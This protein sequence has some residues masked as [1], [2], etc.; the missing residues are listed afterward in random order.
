MCRA[1]V[2]VANRNFDRNHLKIV[3]CR[4]KPQK[5]S[6]PRCTVGAR[7]QNF[8]LHYQICLFIEPTRIY[9]V[10]SDP[11]R[12]HYLP[13]KL[14]ASKPQLEMIPQSE[15]L[16][17]LS[18]QPDKDALLE[19]YLGKS[20]DTLRTPAMII[21]RKLFAQNCSSMHL[22]AREWGASFRA[23][24]KTHKVGLVLHRHVH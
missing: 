8:K 13:A 23:H 20:L 11:S 21:D 14:L 7:F 4:L 18:F 16:Y 3:I 22:K 24:L 5:P 1:A 19:K 6:V 17:K 10:P 15:T 9:L 12:L 2:S